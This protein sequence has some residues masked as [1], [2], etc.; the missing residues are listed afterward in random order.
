MGARTV[1]LLATLLLLGA[2]EASDHAWSRARRAVPELRRADL[3]LTAGQGALLGVLGGFRPLLADLTWIRAYVKWERRDRGCEALLR[4]ACLLDP[5]A[6]TFWEN[7]GNMVG[8]DMAHWEIRARG[9]YHKV[10]ESEQQASFRRFARK[11]IEGLEEGVPVAR[12]PSSLLVLGGY[13]A[14]TKLADPV[15]AADFYRRAH[16]SPP[17]PWYCAYF[18]GRLLRDAGKPREAYAYLRPVWQRE[19]SLQRDGSPTELGFLR[20]LEVELKL[21]PSLRIPRQDWEQ[22][23]WWVR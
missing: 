22:G 14:E 1:L 9:G 23:E 4:L 18:V 8:L 3:E 10:P 15:L 16:E 19:L 6:T 12:R 7:R 11:A 17:A 21:P 13:L 20:G 2:G 5:H